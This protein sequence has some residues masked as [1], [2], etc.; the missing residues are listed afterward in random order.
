MRQSGLPGNDGSKAVATSLTETQ[1]DWMDKF[2]DRMKAKFGRKFTADFDDPD[3]YDVWLD[4]WA[5]VM[6]SLSAEQ[7]KLGMSR[8]GTLEWPPSEGEFRHLCTGQHQVNYEQMF[9]EAANLAAQHLGGLQV[10]WPSAVLYWA[11]KTFGFQELRTAMYEGN[12]RRWAEIVDAVREEEYLQ[13][14]PTEE[15]KEL[16]APGKASITMEDAQKMIQDVAATKLMGATRPDQLNEWGLRPDSWLM[17]VHRAPLFRQSARHAVAALRRF[18]WTDGKIQ[19]F[20]IEVWGL[21]DAVFIAK[22]LGV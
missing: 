3:Y 17:T 16:P 11:A 22:L 20:A 13:P 12:K 9:K 1:R 2:F 4:T 18:R 6:M 8:L 14:I 21:T 7:I 19:K 15:V 10:K 5:A